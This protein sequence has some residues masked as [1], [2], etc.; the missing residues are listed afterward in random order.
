MKGL[1]RSEAKSK[2]KIDNLAAMLSTCGLS[3]SSESRTSDIQSFLGGD[4]IFG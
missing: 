1:Y 4:L 2:I 3:N